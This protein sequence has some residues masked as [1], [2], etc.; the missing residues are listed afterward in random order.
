[1]GKFLCVLKKT[2]L[3][4]AIS[5]DVHVSLETISGSTFSVQKIPSHTIAPPSRIRQILIRKNVWFLEP[6]LS[7]RN[8]IVS[9]LPLLRPLR[10]LE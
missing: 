8:V 10:H 5:R 7:N 3:F 2:L 4:P 1:M 6:S 9:T